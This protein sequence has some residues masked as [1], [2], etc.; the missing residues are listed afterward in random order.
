[1]TKFKSWNY[2]T[3]FKIKLTP[4]LNNFDLYTDLYN[5][6]YTCIGNH[7]TDHFDSSDVIDKQTKA[8]T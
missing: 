8:M 6:L 1:M 4:K 7:W 3:S 2:F 5:S